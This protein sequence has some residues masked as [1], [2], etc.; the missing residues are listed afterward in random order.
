MIK[1]IK[2]PKFRRLKSHFKKNPYSWYLCFFVCF[3]YRQNQHRGNCLCVPYWIMPSWL[4][5]SIVREEVHDEFVNFRKGQ[6]LRGWAVNRHVY[7]GY[8]ADNIKKL[9]IYHRVFWSYI[10]LILEFNWD[11]INAMLNL[12]THI[13]FVLVVRI[14]YRVLPALLILPV[15]GKKVHYELVEFG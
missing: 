7:H 6:H 15:V 11:K 4:I 10:A 9:T 8:V 14:P 2:L 5:F 12:G 13:F 1:E 3:F